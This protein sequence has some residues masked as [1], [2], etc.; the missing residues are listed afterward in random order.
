MAT[1]TL[2]APGPGYRALQLSDGS[3]I[4]MPPEATADNWRA[5]TQQGEAALDQKY[6]AQAASENRPITTNGKVYSAT[7]ARPNGPYGQLMGWLD[8]NLGGNTLNQSSAA[9]IINAARPV[10]TAGARIATAAPDA[11]PIIGGA[12]LIGTGFNVG[13]HLLASAAPGANAIP[14]YRTTPELLRSLTG[15]P[16][17]P[18]NAPPLQKILENTAAAA[19]NPEN[20]AGAFPRAVGSEVGSE[21]GQR[22]G[23]EPG[24]FFG[25]LVG[26]APGELGG[27]ALLRIAQPM[28][29]GK[30]APEVAAAG[31]RQDIQP[32]AGMVMN[33]TGRGIEKVL[34]A[35]P[36]VG[37]PIKAAQERV[38]TQMQNV[39][40]RIA[41]QLYGGPLP[42]GVTDTSIGEDLIGGARQGAAN[43]TQR[44]QDEQ[45]NL[46]SQIGPNQ[47]VNLRPVY[48]GGAA[49]R[50]TTSPTTFAPLAA[51]LD[52]L[53]QMAIEA[54]TPRFQA[55]SGSMPA[56]SAPYSR[57]QNT[58]SDLGADIPG[59]SGMSGG[60]QKGLYQSLTDAMRDAAV[61]KDPALG[62]AFDA[63]NENYQT[64]MAQRRAL[65]QVGGKPVGGYEGLATPGGT[66]A[67]ADF[68]SGS[69]NPPPGEGQA[70][71]WLTKNLRS[72]SKIAPFA[73]PT[74]VPNDYW[75]SVAGQWL[76][77]LGQTK[78]GTYR[79]EWLAQGWNGP[80]TGVDPAVQQ[81]LFT[82]PTGQTT[83]G[84]SDVNDLATMGRNTVVPIERAGLTNTA[85][86]VLAMK[87]LMNRAAAAGGPIAAPLGGRALASGLESPTLVNAMSGNITPLTDALYA[88]VPAA[89]QNILQ[90]QS[91]NNDP[92]YSP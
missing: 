89:T 35:I 67:G 42:G 16:G 23:G 8:H 20:I 2:R 31:Q 62:P 74:V 81:Q 77:Q 27:N 25:A 57:V 58:R 82:G 33:S 18:A 24:Q 44:A 39:Q 51:R 83:S 79:P 10:L 17:L 4:W 69:G 26:G 38:S 80:G 46:A 59:V 85:G 43:I 11:V 55:V 41:E 12:D 34:A 30:Q 65:E 61:A 64:M 7:V 56:G 84:I 52:A 92:A 5:A 19:T 66:T 14:D 50:Y 45:G 63:A 90:Y 91:Q 9:P 73:D 72:P 49:Q 22:L 75:R 6:M 68:Q 53:R 78:E 47:P 29:G 37:A 88:G 40:R 1:P 71:D 3:A 32:T 13:K 36:G 54:Q 76:S 21:I 87:W 15:T 28:L 86:F 60:V 48:Q 70:Y